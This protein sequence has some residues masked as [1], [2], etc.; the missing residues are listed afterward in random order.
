MHGTH[1]NPRICITSHSCGKKWITGC[2]PHMFIVGRFLYL[3]F[4]GHIRHNQLEL[5]K[6]SSLFITVLEYHKGTTI[7]YL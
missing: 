1:T 2:V 3:Y 7:N 4:S 5:N 6:N